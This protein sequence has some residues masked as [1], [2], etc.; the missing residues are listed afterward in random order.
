M[1]KFTS[2][3][4]TA[5]HYSD[6][7]RGE[8]TLVLL[9]GYL[10]SLEVWDDFAGQL[11]KAGYRVI[12]LDLPGHG[13]SEVIGDVHTMEFLA[14][15]VAQLLDKLEIPKA[16]LIG[17]SMGGY[18]ALAFAE[19]YPE[20]L[21]GLVLFHAT[22]DADSEEKKENRKREIGIVQAG[23]K[24]M[25]SRMLPET[26]YA[27]ENRKKMD[28]EIDAGALQV[29]LTEDEGILALL[30]GMMQRRDQNAMLAKLPVPQLFIFGRHDELIPQEK[31]E[32][33][34]AKNPQAQVAWLAHSGHMGFLEEPAE[35]LKIIEHFT[36]VPNA[37][38]HAD[39]S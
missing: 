21:E 9:H 33:V 5:I 24:E 6:I 17:H 16:T 37:L 25:L 14:G 10:E 29:M 2:L 12:S 18:V 30:N 3:G 7:A 32:A 23:R 22:P 27:P 39:K 28:E 36:A 38:T 35:S 13:I 31:A 34:V 19:S 20:K 11:G 1:E 8:K 26:R 15:I 4:D